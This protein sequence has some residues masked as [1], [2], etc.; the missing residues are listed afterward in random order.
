MANE[1]VRLMI[2]GVCRELLDKA[3]AAKA[4][5]AQSGSDYDK[6]RHFA[7]DLPQGAL[8][9]LFAQPDLAKR[10]F[11]SRGR[12]ARLSTY[13]RNASRSTSRIRTRT[14]LRG[15]CRKSSSRTPNLAVRD[16]SVIQ[17]LRSVSS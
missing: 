3:R 2:S 4:G 11:A 17:H 10:R 9:P 1:S 15:P 14:H 13:R 6:G 8:R 7:I 16:S 5:A 12:T